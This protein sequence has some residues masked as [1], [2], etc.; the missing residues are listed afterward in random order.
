MQAIAPLDYAIIGGYL[1][2]SLIMGVL[3]SRRASSSLDHYFLG[4]KKLP[5]YLL[6]V[7]GMANWFD[8]T[9]T[10]I[11][12]AFLY[13]LGP[14]G[15]FIEFRGGA[16][17][18]LAF[19]LAYT[20]KWHRR[21]GCMTGAEWMTYRFGTGKAAEGVRLIIALSSLLFSITLLAVLIRG[22]S[23]FLGMFFPWP[24]FYTTLVLII[25]TTLYTMSS[26]FYGVVLTDLVQGVVVIA[27]CIIVSALAWRMVPGN[28]ELASTA[29]QVTGN[30]DWVTSL[31]AWHTPM[32]PGF[33]AYSP[34]I[35]MAL[36][37]LA[38]NIIGGMGAGAEPRYFGA[39]SDREC[40]LQ[41]LLQ[42]V[43]VM[44]RWPLMIS[45]AV[46][47]IY[48]VQAHFPDPVVMQR[49]A[50]LIKAQFPDITAPYWHDLTSNIVHAPEKYPAHLVA[51]LK[52]ALGDNWPD[53]LPLVGIQGT[54]NPEVILP[55]VL[56][57][58][59][60]SG[61]KGVVLVAMTAALMSC[62]N[63]LVNGAS[64][65]FVKDIYQNFLRPRAGNREL[66][67]ASYFS[68]LSVVLASFFIGVATSN[69]N[70]LFGWL[71]MGLIAGQTAP[72]VLR[73]Y[74][75]RCNAWGMIIGS[76]AGNLGAITQRLVAPQLPETSQFLLMTALSFGGTIIGSLLTPPTPRPVLENF[77]RTTRPFGWWRPLRPLFQGEE[78]AAVDR[79]NRMDLATIP[80]ALLWQVTLFLLPMQLVIKSYDSFLCTLPLFLIGL[81][82]MYFF[83]W[84]PLN[85]P[86][87]EYVGSVQPVTATDREAK[88][89]HT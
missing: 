81:A 74:W 61:L 23:L 70:H 27:S 13:M 19:L 71:I 67:F 57:Q 79:E 17:L 80:F 3:M 10:M 38:R 20:G 25:L 53:R 36:F 22:A 1:L 87:R 32:P 50:G 39:R 34:L 31:P 84:K 26:G 6:G 44:F 18:I 14:R 16:V 54:V 58:M 75:W 49:A 52:A 2:V 35:M 62:K 89:L 59:L 21:S 76:A 11:I 7:A 51:G 5:W 28:A 41:S 45:F 55:A 82:G 88:E 12:T 48:L 9:G 73:F 42:G 4:G 86:P 85:A 83:W 24:P 56:G 33:E 65:Y 8:L 37:Y 64:A 72:L 78:R 46:M 68:T 15:L 30:P 60:P 47:G 40:G 66:I 43:M 63:G 77:Y 29:A 69:I